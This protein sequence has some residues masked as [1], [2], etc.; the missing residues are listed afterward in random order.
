MSDGQLRVRVR[1]AQREAAWAPRYVGNEL[2]GTTQAAEQHRHT[3][4]LRTTEASTTTDAEQRE[5]LEREAAEA[6][7]LADTLDARAAELGEANEARG[8]WLAH[9]AATRAAADRATAELSARHTDDDPAADDTVTA[10]EWLEAHQEAEVAEDPHREITDEHE[11]ADVQRQRAADLDA[12]HAAEPEA[13]PEPGATAEADRTDL[14]EIAAEESAPAD[15]DTVRVP[16]SDE[17]AE[18]VHR[19]QR[20]LAEVA[21]RT[22]A[23]Q[24][25]EAEEARAEQLA[26][27]HADDQT[28]EQTAGRGA[29]RDTA[30][31]L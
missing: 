7:A 16:S 2:A 28:A 23:E 5:R 26:R 18:S 9:T 1:A 21:E 17:T 24:Q 8:K 29:E 31:A 4:S 25:H 22:A 27:W 13:E 10:E 19:A 11:L 15:E 20:A 12:A 3:A 6:A 30:S 14:R